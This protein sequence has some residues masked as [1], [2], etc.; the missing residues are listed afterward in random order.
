[1]QDYWLYMVFN[2]AT[3]PDVHPIQ[4]PVKLGWEPLVKIEHYH[5]SAEKLLE[6]EE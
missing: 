4:N 5:G 2:C 6:V 1:M 3:T